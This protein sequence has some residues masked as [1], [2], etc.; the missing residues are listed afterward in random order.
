MDVDSGD[1]SRSSKK[2][3]YD[4]ELSTSGD[5]QQLQQNSR[6]PKTEKAR[7]LSINRGYQF[8]DRR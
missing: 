3:R 7:Y 5:V 1:E 8:I 4:A 2:Q 6:Q